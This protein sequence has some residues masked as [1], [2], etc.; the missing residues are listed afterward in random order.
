MAD[1]QDVR[2]T[3]LRR[4]VT[5]HEGMNN[6][7]RKLGLTKGSYISQ[8][9]TVPPIRVISEKT[10]RKWES[11][12]GLPSGYMDGQARQYASG[13]VGPLNTNLLAQTI[14]AVS[15]AM[16]KA[17]VVLPPAKFGELVAL[18]YADAVK[19]GHINMERINA[20]VGL[21]AL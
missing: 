16:K 7:A 18:Q 6:L 3:N 9:L 20:I 4:L 2:R 17:A 15:E 10:A 19:E 12:L 11:K 1:L 8:I 5:E 14:A 13:V 21:M